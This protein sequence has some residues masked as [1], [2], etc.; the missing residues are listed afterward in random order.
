MLGLVMG[1]GR[2]SGQVAAAWLGHA[3][4]IFWSA[5]LGMI[6][7]LIIAAAPT[8][9]VAIIGVSVTALGMAVIVPSANSMLG[10]HVSEAQRSHALSRAWMFGI[11]GFFVGPT[12]MGGIAE[13]FGLRAAFVAIALV[14]APVLPAVL[15]MER[16]TRPRPKQA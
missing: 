2:L 10:A 13:W 4:L 14:I 6:G 7:A 15:I 8:P 16:Q 3:L 12:L 11:F 9:A 1:L 5:V